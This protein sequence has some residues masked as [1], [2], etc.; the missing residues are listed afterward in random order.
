MN[1]TVTVNHCTNQF[2]ITKLRLLIYKHTI[3][4]SL[5][6]G[7]GKEQRTPL[8]MKHIFLTY[9]SSIQ[10]FIHVRFFY[11]GFNLYIT[12]LIIIYTP[13]TSTWGKLGIAI[14]YICFI[15]HLSFNMTKPSQRV[16]LNFYHM[17]TSRSISFSQHFMFEKRKICYLYF[18]FGTH[19]E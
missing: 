10:H 14:L 4:L 19:H 18:L 12:K 16:S 5:L 3:T 17:I 13:W 9:P 6:R 7:V 15:K 2:S 8:V 1:Y 11:F